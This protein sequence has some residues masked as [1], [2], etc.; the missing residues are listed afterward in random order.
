MKHLT[1]RPHHTLDLTRLE[2]IDS[3]ERRLGVREQPLQVVHRRR[4]ALAARRLERPLLVAARERQLVQ[5]E[6]HGVRQVERRIRG[7]RGNGHHA[8]ATVQ[9]LVGQPLVFPP[10]EQRD[11][12][13]L[14]A[15]QNLGGRFP[16]ALQIALRRAASRREP[17]DVYAVEQRVLQAIEPGHARQHV[18]RLVRDALDPIRVVLARA[19]QP[20]VAKP[21][22][23]ESP[24]HVGDVAEVP[25][26]VQ[27]DGDGHPT[28]SRMPN[29]SGSCRS[30]RKNTQPLP[31]LQTS[32][33]ARRVRPG[34]ISFTSRSNRSRPP[35]CARC[36]PPCGQ[37]MP[38]VTR[39][40]RSVRCQAPRT[41]SGSAELSL[42]ASTRNPLPPDSGMIRY[43]ARSSPV[44][45]VSFPARY[46]CR[47]SEWMSSGSLSSR[48]AGAPDR[49]S[50]RLN[51]SHAN[52]SYAVFCLKKKKNQRKA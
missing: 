10:E 38:S 51:S 28:S 52:I 45:P 36:P 35:T 8:V 11:G 14:P 27:N 19:H 46:T 16:R 37:A 17:H 13:G 22:I 3:A 25:G 6:H 47:P 21:E 33:P 5:H 49:K 50:T 48:S 12:A 1:Q 2:E 40:P 41:R 26:L 42:V 43:P 4:R 18:L 31:P 39:Y 24:H 34:S 9:R 32:C 44:P 29:R 15:C 20:E 23:L 30:P 7:A